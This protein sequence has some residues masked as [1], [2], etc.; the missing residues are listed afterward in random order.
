MSDAPK[1]RGRGDV[2]PE[3]A[4]SR[5]DFDALR[6]Q[7]EEIQAALAEL[8]QSAGNGMMISR[9]RPLTR[10]EV[11]TLLE[12]SPAQQFLVLA[13]FPELGLRP[14]DRFDPRQRFRDLSAFPLHVERGLQVTIPPQA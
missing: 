4:V 5:A 13:P 9:P 14:S 3:T 6:T 12:A 8:K 11:E 2:A 7:I 1:N 10:K